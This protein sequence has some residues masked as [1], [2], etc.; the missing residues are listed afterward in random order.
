MPILR[1]LLFLQRRKIVPKSCS[2]KAI[3]LHKHESVL[4][5]F[6]K[7]S[8]KLVYFNARGVIEASR[9]MYAIKSFPFEDFRLPIDP[10]TYARPEFDVEKAAGTFVA[11]MDRA[12]VLQVGSVS[13][14]QSK[15]IDRFVAKTVGMHGADLI[16]S[17]QIDMISEHIVDI[18]NSYQQCKTGKT[19]DE[20]EAAKKEWV[21][22][23][24]PT[25]LAKLE[26]SLPGTSFAVGSAIS[27]AD[28]Y[29]FCFITEYFDHKA[30]TLEAAQGFPKLLQSVE[31]VRAAAAGWL[32][33]R[34]ETKL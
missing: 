23:Q 19:G 16:E 15:A 10:V 25:W 32:A 3:Y 14:G 27:L 21:T 7:M 31:A 9:I 12:P 33:S 6:L 5:K 34:P 30:E 24:L 22:A 17:A 4:I 26:K 2:G 8:H 11:N 28:V 29:I 1:L 20:L 18:K 13:I